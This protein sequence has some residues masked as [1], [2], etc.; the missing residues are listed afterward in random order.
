MR[1]LRGLQQEHEQ[2]GDVRGRGLLVGVELVG[3][4]D[5]REPA[6]ALGAAVTGE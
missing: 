2:I 3:D 5:T 4:R 6:D 1:Q